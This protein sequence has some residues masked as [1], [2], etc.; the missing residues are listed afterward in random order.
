MLKKGIDEMKKKLLAVM[1]IVVMV[2]ASTVM[3]FGQTVNV[4][5]GTGSITVPN[6]AKGEEYKLF[7]IFDAVV[8]DGGIVYKPISGIGIPDAFAD[9][10]EENSVGE[11][12]YK[13]G[14]TAADFTAALENW[15]K[16]GANDAQGNPTKSEAQKWI[17]SKGISALSTVTA[18][19]SAVAFTNIPFG[20]YVITSGQ[21][22]QVTVDSTMPNATVYDK[23]SKEIKALKTVDDPQVSI[24]DTVTYTATF[25]TVNYIGEGDAA[26]KV[27]SYT[28]SDTLP[29]FLENVTMTG[30]TVDGIDIKTTDA[31]AYAAYKAGFEG[32]GKS[33]TIPWVT[34]ANN[35]HIYSNGAKIVLTY[36]AKVTAA[37]VDGDGGN[38]NVV[39]IQ[40]NKDKDGNDPFEEYEEDEEKIYTYAAAIKK[41]DQDGNPL[42]GATFKIKGLTVTG[43]KGNYTVSSYDPNGAADSG[44][45]M[46]TD[47]LGMIV[48]RGIED[49]LTLTVTEVKAP[50]GYNK[51]TAPET[52]TV[53]KIS[54]EV[55]ASSV[56][57]YYDAEGNLVNEV[58]TNSKQ[59]V[60][61][62]EKLEPKAL[63]ITN[64]KGSELPS[65]GGMGTTILYTLGGILVVG[66]GVL[67]VA[68]KKMNR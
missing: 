65:T 51:L 24:G 40:P 7:R 18:D 11:I 54:E 19:G 43:S 32:A 68:R 60:E 61:Y 12:V 41:V 56:T 64:N 26:E 27:M 30:L 13:E 4:G 53:V 57:R 29:A 31:T 15:S 1:L 50:D 45:V 34:G 2:L 52:L 23:N 20:Y 17:E 33:F 25:D 37:A 47:D 55:N 38:Q 62:N 42:A 8:G 66:A 63:V 10:V 21:G 58:T 16:P 5:G 28:I 36:T 6:A 48:I 9:I 22:M 59:V 49:N 3:A 39:K 44:T 35:D 67:L 46:E 14:K